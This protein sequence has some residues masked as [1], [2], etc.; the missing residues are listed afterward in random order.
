MSVKNGLI[1]EEIPSDLADLTTLENQLISTYILFMKIKQ[2]P[3]SKIELMVDRTV[4]VPVEPSD[5]MNNVETT[6]LL[7]PWKLVL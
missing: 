7:G 5:V 4:L 2:V 1:V 3:K 6:L